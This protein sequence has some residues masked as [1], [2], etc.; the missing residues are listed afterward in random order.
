MEFLRV[1]RV[2]DRAP[3][4]CQSSNPA[5]EGHKTFPTCFEDVSILKEASAGL[6][7]GICHLLS[8]SAAAAEVSSSDL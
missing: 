8:L 4:S 1:R 6:N 3:N 2:Q 7:S 5:Q